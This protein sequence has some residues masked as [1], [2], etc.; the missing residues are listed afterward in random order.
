MREEE[1][2]NILESDLYEIP[3]FDP[4]DTR[5]LTSLTILRQRLVKLLRHSP[6]GIQPYTNISVKIVSLKCI[7]DIA[8]CSLVKRD[9]TRDHGQIDGFS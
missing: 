6:E 2:P 3:Q 4:I 1:D 9:S 7:K 8:V 5:H